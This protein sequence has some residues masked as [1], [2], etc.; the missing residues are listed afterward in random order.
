VSALHLDALFHK[1]SYP[2]KG[3][4]KQALYAALGLAEDGRRILLGNVRASP[5]TW[6]Y[7]T[8]GAVVWEELLKGLGS[9]SKRSSSSPTA[10]RGSLSREAASISRGDPSGLP[11]GRVAV[12]NPAQT[13]GHP[14][15]APGRLRHTCR[16][17][18]GLPGTPSSR[19]KVRDHKFPKPEAIYKLVYLAHAL[20][21]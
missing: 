1:L 15:P 13:Q 10:F 18:R 21:A 14:G 11:P 7:P 20:G 6:L 9:L 5:V 17:Q 2:G 12:L 16:S 8:E 19:G 3:M 4:V